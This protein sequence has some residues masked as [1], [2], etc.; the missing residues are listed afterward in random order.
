VRDD[1]MRAR[2][3]AAGRRRALQLTWADTARQTVAV[4]HS[5][6]HTDLSH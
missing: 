6:L 2:C 4:Y 3:V 5:V 1:A